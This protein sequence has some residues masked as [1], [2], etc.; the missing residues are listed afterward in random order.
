MLGDGLTCDGGAVVDFGECRMEAE[1]RRLGVGPGDGA[2]LLRWLAV[3]GVW[4]SG[5]PMAARILCTAELGRGGGIRGAG[6]G[7]AS[8]LAGGDHGPLK[9]GSGDLRRPCRALA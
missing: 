1:G 8:W 5:M 7:V 9:E 6:C 2:E 4:R 3:A